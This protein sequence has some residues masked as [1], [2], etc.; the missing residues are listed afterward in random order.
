GLNIWGVAEL[1]AGLKA[2]QPFGIRA[3]VF[4]QLQFNSTGQEHEET[5]TFKG[6]GDNRGDLVRTYTIEPLSF[7]IAAAGKLLF[8]V[9]DFDSNDETFG[10]EL[11]RL[12]GVF[13]VQI[14]AEG[15][16]VLAQA[17]MSIGPPD[18]QLFDL[19][20]LGVLA[21][22]KTGFAADLLITAHAGVHDIASIDGSFRFVTNVSG[23]DQEV[24]VSQRFIDGDYLPQDF[25]DSLQDTADPD[26]GDQKA[27]IVHAGAP[28]WA[29]GYGQAGPY[30]VLQGSGSMLLVNVFAVEAAFRFEVSTEG[31]FIQ[32]E[33][34]LLLKDLGKMN[35]RG[36]LEI[37]SAGLVA[38]MSVDFESPFLQTVGVT[39]DVKADLQINTTNEDR[40]IEPLTDNLLLEPM[41]VPKKTLDVKAAG[42]MAVSI[43]GTGFELARIDGVFSLDTSTE[44]V[45]I[46]SRGDL[47]IG[48]PGL[49][50]F[51]MEV[52]G[53]FALTNNGFAADLYVNATG[54]IA[55]L[56]TL[57]GEFRMVANL[58][59]VRQEVPVPQ[60]FIDGGYLPADFVASL[61]DSVLN[62]GGKAY[63][64]PAG[65]PYLD[66]TPDDAPST[67]MV[68]MGAGALRLADAWEIGGDF[69]IK[70]ETEGPV[71]PIDATLDMGT[72]GTATVLGRVELR[73]SGIVAALSVDLDADG[74]RA[75]G[76]DFSLDAF[77]AVN[78]GE[79]EATITSDTNPNAA[80]I[81][82]PGHTSRLGASGE[83]TIRVPQTTI[84]LI[85]LRGTFLMEINAEGM[86]VLVDADIPL[87]MP[88]ATFVSMQCG[89]A[90]FI[91]STGVAMEIDVDFV[92]LGVVDIFANVFSFRVTS[93]L[94]LNTSGT[95]LE[96]EV[97]DNFIP[98]L[99]DRAQARLSPASDGSGMA[100]AVSGGAP[101]SNGTF[102]E[103]GAYSV[104]MMHGECTVA[105]VF[106]TEG[107]YRMLIAS[108]LFEVEFSAD[109]TLNPLGT[110]QADGMLSVSDEGVYGTLQ[111][112]GSF[113][114][115]GL[116]IYGAM[117]LELNTTG[118]PVVVQRLQYDFDSR[119]VRDETITVTLPA[120]TMRINADGIMEIPGFELQ[121]S[122]ELI[123]NSD[124]ISLTFDATFRAFDALFLQTSGTVAIPKGANP[125]IVI[126]L[127]ATVSSGFFGVD[128][129]FEMNSTFQLKV[130]TRSG[131]GQDQYDLGLSRGMVRIDINGQM[132]LL[133]TLKLQVAGYIESRAGVFSMAVSGSMEI[134][135]Q[136][137]Y[138]NAFFSSE[139]EFQVGFGGSI[140]IGPSG[141]G[142]SG[143][144]SFQISRLDG[145]GTAPYGDGNYV[146][147][148]SGLVQGSVRLFGFTLGS[149]SIAFGLDGT[150][151][152]VYI[153]PSIT[154]NF[155]LFSITV[156][157]TFNLFYVKVPRPVFLAGNE[158]DSTGTAFNRGILYLNT[159]AR[160]H[161]RNEAEE[162]INEG[163]VISRIGNDPDYPGE[164]VRIQAFGRSQ[165]F[166]GVTGI[167]GDL[168]TGHDYLE[169]ESGVR[170]PLTIMGGGGYDYLIQHGS[171]GVYF[172][173]DEGP[174]YVNIDAG[175][176][177]DVV[178][179]GGTEEDDITV[180][181]GSPAPVTI[182]AGAGN[183]KIIYNGSA[184]A[185]IGGGSGDDQI[186]GGS[187]VNVFQFEDDFGYDTITKLGG[188]AEMDF[189]RLTESIDARLTTTSTSV[190]AS[191]NW[192]QI[193]GRGT[194]NGTAVKLL[195]YLA[196]TITV[197]FPEHNFQAGDVVTIDSTVTP[198]YNGQFV[199]QTVSDDTFTIKPHARLQDGQPATLSFSSDV[200]AVRYGI[201]LF[202]D[203]EN[204]AYFEGG[205]PDMASGTTVWLAS[206]NR[207][208]N[209]QFV[210]ERIDEN[211][212]AVTLPWADAHPEVI[213]DFLP[214]LFR[215]GK[216]DDL[217]T[218]NSDI[219]ALPIIDNGGYDRLK[220]VGSLGLFARITSTSLTIEGQTLQYSNI[221]FVLLW[222]PSAD[223]TVTG[224]TSTSAIFIPGMTLGIVAQSLSLPVNV[225]AAALEV[226]VRDSLDFEHTLQLA[227]LDV[228]VFGDGSVIDFQLPLSISSSIQL[229]APDGVVSLASGTTTTSAL[230]I[231]ARG[232][233]TGNSLLPLS[234]DSFTLVTDE[235]HDT[236][237]PIV[238]DRDLLLTRW[239]DSGHLITLNAGIIEVFENI[240]WV[241]N[242]ASDWALQVFD[243]ALNP[244]A[245][246]AKGAISVRLP[247]FSQDDEDGLT[248]D[249]RIRSYAGTM[250]LTADEMDF[251]G[252]QGS[253][254]A[255][256]ALTIQSA[257]SVWSYRLGT[258]AEAQSGAPLSTVV[259]PNSLDLTTRDLAALADGFES[260]TI[261]RSD[262]G[263][264]MRIGDAYDMT[265][266]KATG[267][268]RIQNAEIKD[269]I[270]LW[271]EQFIVEGDFR[272][273]D[274][275][276]T[277][278]GRTLE[279][280]RANLHTPENATP[281]SGL[282][283]TRTTLD[284]SEQVVV[285]G[286]VL[287]DDLVQIDV[288]NS[289]GQN[290]IM[291][292][293][294]GPNSV[295]TGVGS[296]IKTLNDGSVI[297]ITG[298]GSIL[299]ASTVEAAGAGSQLL[300][301]AG[302]T[303]LQ[304]EGGVLRVTG[305]GSQLEIG[306]GSY[307]SIEA[308]SAVLAGV[309]F[310]MQGSTPVP[311]STGANAS[312]TITAPG[313][314][315]L[316][317]SIASTGS[318]QLNSGLKQLNHAEYFDTLAGRLRASTAPEASVVADL[319]NN[320]FPESL[321]ATF[322][323]D[324]VLLGTSV[325][326]T[327]LEQDRR[328]LATDENQTQYVIYL[329][330]N[331]NDQ[332]LDAIQVLDPHV[333]IGQRGFGFLVTGTLTVMDAN[334]ALNLQ[335]T[336][337]VLI[338]GNINLLG[339]GSDLVLQSDKWVYLE[340]ELQVDGD[341]T[342]Y[343]GVELDGTNRN[344]VGVNGSSVLIPA[345]SR[346]IATG[347]GSQIDIRGVKDVDV[348]GAVVAGGTVTET[349]VTWAG[350]DA[351]IRIQ[352]G[353]QVYID[354]GV[355]AA[356]SVF[357]QGGTA[358]AD[359]N[360][361]AVYLTTASGIT[362]A[363]LTSGIAGSVVEI[364][365]GSDIQIQ[366][367]VVSGG[368]MHQQ[369]NTQ[370]KRIGETFTW[371]AKPSSI[372]VAAQE[373]QAWIGGMARTT[374]GTLA[375]TGGNLWTTSSLEI[376]GGVNSTDI[377]VRIS[378]A[379]QL[380]AVDP[381]A[382]I[383]MNSAGDADLQGSIVAGGTLTRTFDSSGE[384]LGRTI[385]PLDGDS[386]IRVQADN[387]IRLG[388]DL[389]AGKSIDLVGGVDPVES[390]VPYS[391]NGILQS[392]LV[393]ISTWRPGSEVNLNAPG[394]ISILAPAHT[395]EIRAEGFVATANGRLA[396]NVTLSLWLSKVDFDITAQ[397]TIPAASTSSN[398][399]VQDL[400][401]DIQVALNA[402]TWKVV[403]TDTPAHALNSNY[404]FD[405]ANPDLVPTL[406]ESRIVLTSSYRHRLQSNSV[407]ANL[408]GFSLS[409]A[410]LVS[411][412]PYAIRA[413]QPG[414]VVRIGAP[415][416]PNGKLYI[417]G[418]V[419]AHTEIVLYSGAPEQGV[420]AD[421]V[422]VELEATGSL[423][424]VNGSITLS[425]GAR[426]VL[427]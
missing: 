92:P 417:A 385:T 233:Q 361:V 31:L 272:V 102:E 218:L 312:L 422:Y 107:T 45:T 270:T 310:Q 210:I 279:V 293:S 199:V 157:T 345:T 15:L 90:L 394:K 314:M 232:L 79:E 376:T 235:N 131:S 386:T 164:I 207:G 237:L 243:G 247:S 315:W 303:F 380:V 217:L 106:S 369:F 175:V 134:L 256:L 381:A 203:G 172:R 324:S 135:G 356:G 186:Q 336:D 155:F 291:N 35:A 287:G 280:M 297:Q 363:G 25:I 62:P 254:Q 316:A 39:M 414:S 309:A 288:P 393:Q 54:G 246:V 37:T 9:P 44:R 368:T 416:G 38:A 133:S 83:L 307:L 366:G 267:V 120:D 22:K 215:T 23:V 208:Y 17:T 128:A 73:M 359:D 255:P 12:S 171:G 306:G 99:S 375:E 152:R 130:N 173:G 424:T 72:I 126:N 320:I 276:L 7:M 197:L 249:G 352:A 149:A 277:L 350:P 158:F 304:R 321:R 139:G 162:E 222:D 400:L 273:P 355:L 57:N 264:K 333:L 188:T 252:G 145:N 343:G 122:F 8:H 201:K 410:D 403:R 360:G 156:S 377:G 230:A 402:A 36:Y 342:I 248:V 423:E 108:N 329:A 364:R 389:R 227:D 340:G 337:D 166:R 301:T 182:L 378:A 110:V 231:R 178:I 28:K 371:T 194:I 198:E 290:A 294:S 418:K 111:L 200:S 85:T 125:G 81:V 282:S 138:G 379:S 140:Q 41:T 148:V 26:D 242:V 18:L 286:W 60:R 308:G 326:L 190:E 53:V 300:M 153:T 331:N 370:G 136:S 268:P 362:A 163:Y 19:D 68:V 357:V 118:G 265:V 384:F 211:W 193:V 213:A 161:M 123:N 263:N 405:S 204:T 365:S 58:T 395:Q 278:H 367:T 347:S 191:R 78:T 150:T 373:G 34:G 323:A 101:R 180:E 109:M 74:L 5:L 399:S 239:V 212:Y 77:L 151:G 3:D 338:R 261:G 334:Q 146:L 258:A 50:V 181:G 214:D 415:A 397:V 24:K 391:G 275:P 351:E 165:T 80:P 75:A 154:I 14:N 91:R 226:N 412:L 322:V 353:Q 61:A 327:E 64:V 426:T 241:A 143:S 52:L 87:F 29:G 59:G 281:D 401:A 284:I 398:T 86:S 407:A 176:R 328:W 406:A 185:L 132:I 318:M 425:P 160:A 245:V 285:S 305:S 10:L 144:T 187:G 311:V 419:L 6:M 117:Q 348:L 76:A 228:R 113:N 271:A 325:T 55:S 319:Q 97:P 84:E 269:E 189:S 396:Q 298:T 404:T 115:G 137:M 292:F 221:E 224:A 257:T 339:T 299:H 121:G 195:P 40:I 51:D 30:A 209:G 302:T 93:T 70:V 219:P 33:G 374:A 2:L 105:S 63:F 43:P 346:L 82:I 89:G 96:I 229:S 1:Q 335:V 174:T 42:L 238:N 100:Y 119:Q 274:N 392:G 220:I 177:S 98:S 409:G 332:T 202:H 408:L 354:T 141:F 170:A 179:Y 114:L 382:S 147:N 4:A 47:E 27:Y 383:I 223:L 216:G 244:Y 20:A 358:G 387:Q 420:A 32:A 192:Q 69:R 225:T 56:A 159:G 66:G 260:I 13:S 11:F 236:E 88:A 289:M 205:V 295:W 48:P 250:T 196:H 313:E 21:I 283:A 129:I 183:D 372:V 234:V 95:D 127:A 344:G 124:A 94:V 251:Q 413:D 65:A 388:R 49:H 71:I 390:G 169:I 259:A 167:V 67:Y 46:F 184:A 168:G 112:G 330:D 104:V 16:E 240:T 317:G 349:G 253:V 427:L 262:A 421:N 103:P 142:V 116:S 341:I 206:S 411:S 266:V 296:M